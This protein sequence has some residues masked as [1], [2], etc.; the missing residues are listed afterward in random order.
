MAY[1][2]KRRYDCQLDKTAASQKNINIRTAFF[3]APEAQWIE[4]WPPKPKVARSIRAEKKK[5]NMWYF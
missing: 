2:V 4:C 1:F 3:S 5:K